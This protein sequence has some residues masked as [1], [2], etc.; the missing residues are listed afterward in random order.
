MQKRILTPFFHS[1]RGFTLIEVVASMGIA[2]LALGGITSALVIASRATDTTTGSSS[3]TTDARVAIDRLTADLNHALSFSE[4]TETAVTFDVPDRDGDGSNE[5][6]RYAWSGTAGDPLTC[7]NNA[8]S[9]ITMAENVGQFQ[10]SYLVRPPLPVPDSETTGT[11]LLSYYNPSSGNTISYSVDQSHWCAQ[12]FK[13]TLPTN[14]IS[15]NVDYVYLYLRRDSSYRTFKIQ[16]RTANARQK[17]TTQGLDEVTEYSSNLPSSYS[18]R[19]YQFTGGASLDPQSGACLVVKQD[20][21]SCGARILYIR[22]GSSMPQNSHW[23]STGNAGS[24][25][26]TPVNNKDM[27]FYVY[28]TITT[29]GPAQW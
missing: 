2:A 8:G 26:S 16:I 19:Y 29:E 14:T 10:L 21:S 27:L 15:W 18:W 20:Y 5:T 7:L 9:E 4:Q 24:S 1:R 13:P 6:I 17:P 22:N 11:T 12:Y 23:V 25:W 3:Q 28:G